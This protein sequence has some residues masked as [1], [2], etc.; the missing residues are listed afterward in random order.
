MVGGEKEIYDQLEPLF[1]DLAVENGY[2]YAGR[3][4]SGH[5][6]K[7]VHNGIEIRNDEQLLKDLKC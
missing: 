2:S 3:V 4:G 7:M 1:K 6:L 5:F